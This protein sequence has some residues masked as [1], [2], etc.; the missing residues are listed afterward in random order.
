MGKRKYATD[1]QPGKHQ[2]V[3]PLEEVY[4]QFYQ[5]RKCR[6]C[7]LFKQSEFSTKVGICLQRGC[8]VSAHW[9]CILDADGKLRVTRQKVV[10]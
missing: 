4:D 1:I 9:D 6:Y 2:K 3:T 5:E 7:Q 8:V 10:R